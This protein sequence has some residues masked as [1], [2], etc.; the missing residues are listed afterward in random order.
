MKRRNSILIEDSSTSNNFHESKKRNEKDALKVVENIHRV[1][2]TVALSSKKQID[3]SIYWK[4]VVQD[5]AKKLDNSARE[6]DLHK[7]QAIG[8]H[9]YIY[10]IFSNSFFYL[11]IYNLIGYFD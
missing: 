3:H 9:Y 6:K 4:L 10:Y 2:N 11:L 5:F 1:S 7:E 8:F